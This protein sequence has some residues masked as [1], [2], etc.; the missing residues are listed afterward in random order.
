MFRWILHSYQ[1]L[2]HLHNLIWL[3]VTY[4]HFL[5]LNIWILSTIPFLSHWSHF[6]END[7]LF[8]I[9][10]RRWKTGNHHRLRV[11]TKR[12]LEKASQ[13][14][15]PEVIIWIS[16]PSTNN[17]KMMLAIMRV[18]RNTRRS[19]GKSSGR[20]III[21]M[22]MVGGWMIMI[23]LTYTG[24][25]WIV[26]RQGQRWRFPKQRGTSWSLSPA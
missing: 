26:H 4:M 9:I 15:V 16:E 25:E 14:A 21:M 24:C 12:V 20:C 23:K 3:W 22:I 13:F 1:N 19:G 11:S 10:I 7:H 8:I 6:E 18:G 2:H 5:K 17:G